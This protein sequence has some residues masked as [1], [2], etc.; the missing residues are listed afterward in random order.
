MYKFY[1]GYIY[2]GTFCENSYQ[3]K[4]VKYFRKKFRDRC[5]TSSWIRLQ[6]PSDKISIEENAQANK[7]YVLS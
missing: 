4:T 7:C 6:L 1:F 5:S 3:L 2:D